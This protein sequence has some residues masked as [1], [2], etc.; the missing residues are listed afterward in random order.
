MIECT[1]PLFVPFFH[2]L[3]IFFF[4]H[5]SLHKHLLFQRLYYFVCWKIYKEASFA[6]YDFSSSIYHKEIFLVKM[7]VGSTIIWRP[8]K[9]WKTCFLDGSLSWLGTWCWLLLGGLS[10]WLCGTI[11]R[12]N[13]IS[14]QY[15]GQLLLEQVI[16][17]NK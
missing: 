12:A 13:W 1:F 11:H 17:K 16:Q 5:T 10:F 9:S 4:L 7:V 3:F 8:D 2:L 15:G 14:L 6:N